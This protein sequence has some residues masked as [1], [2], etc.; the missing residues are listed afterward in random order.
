MVL[1]YAYCQYCGFTLNK[2]PM[3]VL[4]IL[5]PLLVN[6]ILK[7]DEMSNQ[8]LLTDHNIK[9]AMEDELQHDS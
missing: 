5:I 9:A 3:S 8:T 7:W 4:S 1:V 6:G 2:K